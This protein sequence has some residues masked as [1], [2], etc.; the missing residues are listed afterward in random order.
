[1]NVLAREKVS[2]GEAEQ[3][4][5][6]RAFLDTRMGISAGKVTGSNGRYKWLYN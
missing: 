1:L 2:K 3:L 4:A 5:L 6:A